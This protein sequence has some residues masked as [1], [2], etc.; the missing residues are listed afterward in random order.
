MA[1]LPIPIFTSNPPICDH[2]PQ[3]VPRQLAT[4]RRTTIEKAILVALRRIDAPKPE[5][6]AA[7]AQRI[8]V[9]YAHSPFVNRATSRGRFSRGGQGGADEGGE[10]QGPRPCRSALHNQMTFSWEN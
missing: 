10:G 9:H 7:Q 3:L 2:P 4:G 6:I 1:L 8:T 5:T